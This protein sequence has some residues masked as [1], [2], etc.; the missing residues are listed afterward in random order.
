MDWTCW[1]VVNNSSQTLLTHYLFNKQCFHQVRFSVS[2]VAKKWVNPVSL[3]VLSE[4]GGQIGCGGGGGSQSA[5]AG[6]PWAKT[7]GERAQLCSLPA[8]LLLIIIFLH[9]HVLGWK[10]VLIVAFTPSEPI[11]VCFQLN[12]NQ[13]AHWYFEMGSVFKPLKAWRGV[14]CDVPLYQN[15]VGGMQ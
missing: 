2:S 10:R 11:H 14:W 6:L 4:R 7:R 9:F 1:S 3:H 5:W 8:K 15:T 12:L 13:A